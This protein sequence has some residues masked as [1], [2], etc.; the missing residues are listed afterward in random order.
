MTLQQIEKDFWDRLF[1]ESMRGKSDEDVIL[2]ALHT[3]LREGIEACVPY[4][5]LI[6]G[7]R[8]YYA[9]DGWNAAVA[10]MRSR[11]EELLK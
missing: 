2:I 8:R 9:Q 7:Q 4:E 10:R 11:M 1:P 3:A 6:K 5:K